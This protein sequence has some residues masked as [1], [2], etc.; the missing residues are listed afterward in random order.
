VRIR[1]FKNEHRL[2]KFNHVTDHQKRVIKDIY[3][4]KG[5]MHPDSFMGSWGGLSLRE[6]G[7]FG[8][9]RRLSHVYE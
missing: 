4:G 8:S 5:P 9:A 1:E 3:K 2:Q 6:A 7:G